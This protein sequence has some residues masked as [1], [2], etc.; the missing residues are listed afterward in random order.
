MGEARG[1]PPSVTNRISRR[2]FDKIWKVLRQKTDR[3][4]DRLRLEELFEAETRISVSHAEYQILL[5]GLTTKT[6]GQF[7]EPFQ[8]VLLRLQGL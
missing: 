2:L 3:F 4:I 7:V 1:I 6:P 8:R 5:R